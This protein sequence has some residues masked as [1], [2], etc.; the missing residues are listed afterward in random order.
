MNQYHQ[1]QNLHNA[2]KIRHCKFDHFPDDA[3]CILRQNISIFKN[4]GLRHS[5]NDTCKVKH[6]AIHVTAWNNNRC[7]LHRQ[8]NKLTSTQNIMVRLKV[9]PEKC[10]KNSKI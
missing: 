9:F 4:K 7:V 1:E 5:H 10:I 8:T 2:I 3:Y 6:D